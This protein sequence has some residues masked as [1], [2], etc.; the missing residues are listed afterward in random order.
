MQ[1]AYKELNSELMKDIPALYMDRTKFFTPVLATVS[2]F[3]KITT[4][5]QNVE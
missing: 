1:E 4:G 5:D 3:F 2:I